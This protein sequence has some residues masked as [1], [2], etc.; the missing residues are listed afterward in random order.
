MRIPCP[1]CGP[2]DHAE[3]DYGGDATVVWPALDDT[4]EAWVEALYFRDDP[5]GPHRELW[6]HA[7]GCRLWLIVERD[8]VTHEISAA[9]PAHPG[10]ADEVTAQSQ[11]ETP[12]A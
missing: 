1:Y 8:T 2:R 7:R 6:R 4:T 12:S 9:H 11:A 10:M 3:F 5:K